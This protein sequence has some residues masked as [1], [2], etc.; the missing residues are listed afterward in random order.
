MSSTFNTNIPLHT[1]NQNQVSN[2]KKNQLTVSNNGTNNNNNNYTKLLTIR[3]RKLIELYC[4]SRLNELLHIKDENNFN[5]ELNLFLSKND[6]SVNR[7]FQINTL[8]NQNQTPLSNQSPIAT[9]F[10]SNLL[11]KGSLKNIRRKSISTS[12]IQTLKN[13][14]NN[15]NDNDNYNKKI[16]N[17]NTNDRSKS[18]TIPTTSSMLNYRSKS[19]SPDKKSIKIPLNTINIGEIKTI[20]NDSKFRNNKSL[21][22]T[23]PSSIVENISS[24]NSANLEMPTNKKRKAESIIQ[25]IDDHNQPIQKKN[26]VH[27]EDVSYTYKNIGSTASL[28]TI[29]ISPVSTKETPLINTTF[30]INPNMKP[31]KTTPVSSNENIKTPLLKDLME[32]KEKMIERTDGYLQNNINAKDYMY[33]LMKDNIPSKVPHAVP[34]AELR[35]MAQTLPLVNLIPK[36]HKALTTE[37]INGAL[38]ESRITVVSSRIEELKRLGLWSLRQPKKFID[39]WNN[40]HTYYQILLDEAKWMQADFYEG[41]KYKIAVCTIIAQAVM[42]YWT[43]GKVCCIKPKPPRYLDKNTNNNDHKNNEIKIPLSNSLKSDEN[44]QSVYKSQLQLDKNNNVDNQNGNSN[45]EAEIVFKNKISTSSDESNKEICIDESNIEQINLDKI[46]NE[47]DVVI[48]SSDEKRKLLSDRSSIH[49]EYPVSDIKKINKSTATE[50]LSSVDDKKQGLSNNI[51]NTETENDDVNSAF[52]KSDD[53]INNSLEIKSIDVS[54]LLKKSDLTQEINLPELPQYSEEEYEKILSDKDIKP[55]KLH[56]SLS[57]FTSA[58]KSIMEQVPIYMG[59]KK[60]DEPKQHHD[61]PFAPISKS[62]VTLEDDEFYKLVERQFVEEEQSLVQLSKRRGM[63]YGNRRSHYL[64][65]PPVPSLKYLQNR[66]PTI[67]LPEDDQELVRNINTYAYNWELISA[68]MIHRSSKSYLSNIERRTPWQCFERFVQLNEKFNFNDLKGPRAHS[69][70]QWLIE[71]HRFQQRQNRRI[72]PLGVG[73]ESVQRGHRRLRWASMF[74]V[75]R[76]CIKKRENAPRPNPTQPRKPMDCRNM[77]IPTPAE[78]SQLKAQ[79]DEALRRDI[80]LRRNAKN[81]LHQR[82]LQTSQHN[83]QQLSKGQN[84]AH[85]T[86][87]VQNVNAQSKISIQLSR[88]SSRN[89]S[90]STD[91][92][93]NSASNSSGKMKTN[94]TNKSFL[95]KQHANNNGETRYTEEEIIELYARK[96]QLQK[97]NIPLETALQTARAYYKTLKNDQQQRVQQQSITQLGQ[98]SGQSISQGDNDN[99]SSNVPAHVYN[100]IINNISTKNASESNNINNNSNNNNNNNSDSNDNDSRVQNKRGIIDSNTSLHI[101]NTTENT[102]ANAVHSPTPNEILQKFQK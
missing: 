20:P 85:S 100:E 53:N 72:S 39:P 97:P 78:M 35:Y 92:N 66:T 82:Q 65:P 58:E 68:N 43:Y 9:S 33:L 5:N 46:N 49:P 86:N 79:R 99:K 95:I 81:K 21:S 42:D 88:G 15:N 71:A 11:S 101:N 60:N 10:N 76:R 18:V 54:K 6:M 50:A 36:T 83:N 45:Q 7:R 55:F 41:K 47:N 17:N 44:I 2:G 84:F 63:F 24:N 1:S 73:N 31:P 62:I 77:K 52:I 57:E 96:I 16:I 80:Q 93:G 28:D 25:N 26:K 75:I 8:P 48:K 69:A 89:R 91:N 87:Q 22:T 12:N 40:K 51:E 94:N 29:N 102:I 32:E 38:N 74:E 64:R 61:I 67:W 56:L 27:F 19:T 14:N 23:V 37:I 59:I 30:Y 4:V 98:R 13:N 70:Q 3:N 90:T 34:L